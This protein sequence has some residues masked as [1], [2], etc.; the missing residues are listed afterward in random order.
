MLTNKQ[1]SELLG[2]VK[3]LQAQVNDGKEYKSDLKKEVLRLYKI[4][5]PDI[6]KEI[7][8]SV[9]NKMDIKELKEFKKSLSKRANSIIKPLPQLLKVKNEKEIK[10]NEKFKI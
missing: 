2:Y 6:N 7:V 8:Q 3:K 9:L 5:Q 4:A 1:V 10:S